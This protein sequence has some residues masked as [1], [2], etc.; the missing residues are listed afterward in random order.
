[1]S[2]SS[3]EQLRAFLRGHVDPVQ[4][5][6]READ[7]QYLDTAVFEGVT[8]SYP[9]FDASSIRHFGYDQFR[10]IVQRCTLAS[11]M[12][13]GVEIFSVEGELLEV[14]LASGC[15]NQWCFDLLDRHVPEDNVSYC[16]TYDVQ[17]DAQH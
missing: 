5:K 11:V 10:I 4:C 7:R 14:E 8:A 15:V 2:R 17:R 16:A 3:A 9:S 6:R 12:V 1:M 13:L